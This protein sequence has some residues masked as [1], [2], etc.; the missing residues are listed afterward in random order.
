[1]KKK[2]IVALPF[3]IIPI[4]IPIYEILDNLILV[5]IFGCGCVPIAQ[6]NMFNI[7]FNANDLRMTVFSILTIG[8]SIWSVSV[9]K[10]FSK[11]SIKRLYCLAVM[12]F[13]VILTVW[14]MKTFMW[15]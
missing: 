13:N 11:K 6:T 8:L 3:V 2:I 4:F 12:I 5:D 15:G 10:T 14:V 1:M 7:P 9:S